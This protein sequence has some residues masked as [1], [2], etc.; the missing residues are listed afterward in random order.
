[1]KKYSVKEEAAIARKVMAYRHSQDTDGKR[2]QQEEVEI[3]G[4][5]TDRGVTTYIVRTQ[6]GI[7]CTAI[8]NIFTN[9]FYADDVHGVIRVDAPREGEA[10]VM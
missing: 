4:C 9:A 1:M 3:I 6:D 2:T 8:R 7:E 5:Q 10:S